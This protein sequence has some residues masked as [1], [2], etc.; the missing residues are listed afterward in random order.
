MPFDGGLPITGGQLQLSTD[1]SGAVR[2]GGWLLSP[3]RALVATTDRTGMAPVNGLPRSP[4]GALVV[5]DAAVARVD[6]G[7]PLSATGALA[8][9]T[10]ASVRASG[11]WPVDAGG[12]VSVT[13]LGATPFA[14]DQLANLALWLKADSISPADGSAVASLADSAGSGLTFAQ[15]TGT[16]QPL[17]IASGIGGK[18]ALDFDGIDDFL[19]IGSSSLGQNVSGLTMCVVARSDTVVAADRRLFGLSGNTI[20]TSRAIIYQGRNTLATY[21]AGGRRLSAD[22][23]Q[24]VNGVA[25]DLNP[26]IQVAK[27]DFAGARLDHWV[28][29]ATAGA[30][31]G[32]QTAGLSE[33]SAALNSA[34]GSGPDGSGGWFDGRIAEVVVYHRALPDAERDSVESYLGAKYGI[35]VI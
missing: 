4:A 24:E 6:G 8:V 16:K 31:A 11:G 10:A 29:G 21:G 34:I 28:N 25:M 9:T 2:D 1:P 5:E 22:V 13:G 12:R 35:A 19:I 18:P 23:F 33:N 20:S 7:V 17:W 3:A 15:A 30:L 27:F 14:P 26:R 32:F